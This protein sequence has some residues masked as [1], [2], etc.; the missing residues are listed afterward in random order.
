MDEATQ[1]VKSI[2]GTKIK[3]DIILASQVMLYYI[4]NSD[5]KGGLKLLRDIAATVCKSKRKFW[6]HQIHPRSSS[7]L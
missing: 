1:I 7:L 2:D 4:K 5:L 3:S 6:T